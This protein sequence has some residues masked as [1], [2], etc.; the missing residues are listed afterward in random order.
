MT[1]LKVSDLHPWRFFLD[2]WSTLDKESFEYRESHNGNTGTAITAYVFIVAAIAL[3]FS[4]L[5]YFGGNAASTRLILFL[6][7]SQSRITHP[8][9][10]NLLSWLIPDNGSIVTSGYLELWQLG[11]WTAIKVLAYLI[12]PAVAIAVHPKLSFK[13]VGLDT[14][15]F[16]SHIKI[17]AV[18]FLP[19]L[20]AVIAISFTN[21]FT[22]YYPFYSNSMR[23]SFDFWAWELMYIAQFFAL[24]FFFRGFILQLSKNSMGSSAIVAMMLP[25]VML[26]FGKPLPECF[27]AVIAGVILGTLALKTRSIWAGFFLHVSVALSMDIA[28]N[29]QKSGQLF[30]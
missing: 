27:A 23:S 22:E 11:F 19:V 3:T 20:A 21:E 13:M 26:H 2:T 6:D 14:S 8:I 15:D 5:N 25:Y 29:L 9:L 30:F 28:S 17:Y 1:A 16:F 7:S 4:D 10:W 24:E 18:L 12:F